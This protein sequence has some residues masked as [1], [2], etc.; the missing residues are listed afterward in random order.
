MPH[1][2]ARAGGLAATLFVAALE[3]R[4]TGAGTHPEDDPLVRAAVTVNKLTCSLDAGLVVHH[5]IEVLGG[6]GTIEDLSPLPRLYR[7]VPVQETPVTTP[8]R[9]GYPA[10]IA[11]LIEA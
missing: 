5:A 4:L 1:R 2:A 3:D 7:E 6:N 10:R 8:W 11:R 9:T